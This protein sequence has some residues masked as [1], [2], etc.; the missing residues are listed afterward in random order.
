M[1]PSQAIANKKYAQSEKGKAAFARAGAKYYAKNKEKIEDK[2]LQKKYGITLTEW[3]LRFDDQEGCCAICGVHQ[4]EL[5][6]VLVVDHDHET[7]KV[8]GL[9]CTPC[10]TSLGRFGDNL[11]GLMR[12]VNYL[13]KD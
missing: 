10:N 9:L 6:R 7:D 3:N 5:K 4:S 2:R 1:T 12:A 8:R 11:E 13:R